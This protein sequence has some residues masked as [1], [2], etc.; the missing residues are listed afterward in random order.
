MPS[1][2]ERSHSSPGTSWKCQRSLPVSASTASSVFEYSESPR[3]REAVLHGVGW[4]VEKYTSLS[5]AS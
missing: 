5:S 2:A 1:Y 3:P 4:P